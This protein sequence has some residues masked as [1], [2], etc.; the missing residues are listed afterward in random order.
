M[1]MIHATNTPNF[2]LRTIGQKEKLSKRQLT[3]LLN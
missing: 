3:Q 1:D 2:S